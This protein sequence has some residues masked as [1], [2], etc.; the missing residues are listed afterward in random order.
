MAKKTVIARTKVSKSLTNG[1]QKGAV[2]KARTIN[3][4]EEAINQLA[5]FHDTDNKAGASALIINS[6]QNGAVSKVRAS[7]KPEDA[8]EN[9]SNMHNVDEL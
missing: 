2:P 4:A 8:I 6:K 9:I 5:G 1:K 7:K 3:D